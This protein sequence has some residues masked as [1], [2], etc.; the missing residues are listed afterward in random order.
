MDPQKRIERSVDSLQRLYAGIV[1][2]AIAKAISALLLADGAPADLGSWS[3]VKTRLPAFIAL[4]SLIV[5]FVQGMNR[6][7]DDCYLG[8]Q[9]GMSAPRSALLF[10]FFSFFV[11]SGLLFAV[12]A[13]L[14]NPLRAFGILGVV[15]VL[16]VSW[17]FIAWA[18]HHQ[19]F[20][21]STSGVMPWL[22]VNVLTLVVGLAVSFA[23]LFRAETI[24]WA[25]TILAL[26]RTTAD[27][28][29][30]WTFYFPDTAPSQ[31]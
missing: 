23:G 28:A 1:A 21:A 4:I 18:I 29:F 19:G 3:D 8:G 25:L 26:A 2:L 7:L 27:Y 16:D 24:P 9:S 30:G 15:L 14:T 11:E 10:D 17:A 22:S 31:V 20:P 6:H 5:P 13:S 12:S